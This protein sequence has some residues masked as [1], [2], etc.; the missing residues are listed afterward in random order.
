MEISTTAPKACLEMKAILQHPLELHA[1]TKTELHPRAQRLR[2][3]AA[4]GE[5]LQAGQANGST[6]SPF[7]QFVSEVLPEGIEVLFPTKVVIQCMRVSTDE[8]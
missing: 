3:L 6:R 7:S 1:H 5:A 2:P 8:V 4:T